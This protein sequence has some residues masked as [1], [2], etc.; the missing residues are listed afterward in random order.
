MIIL[1]QKFYVKNKLHYFL[2]FSDEVADGALHS[3]N[4]F[5]GC[6]RNIAI[7]DRRVEWVDMAARYNVGSNACPTF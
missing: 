5:V 6:L 2:S 7:N 3:R 1:N 4:N